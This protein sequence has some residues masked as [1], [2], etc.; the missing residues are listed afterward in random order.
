[1]ILIRTSTVWAIC[2]FLSLSLSEDSGLSDRRRK[3]MWRKVTALFLPAPKT[4]SG[5]KDLV[6]SVLAHATSVWWKAVRRRTLSLTSARHRTNPSTAGRS[7]PGRYPLTR[8]IQDQPS[9][10]LLKLQARIS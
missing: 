9:F 3:R 8:D 1:M 2:D 7:G 10:M 6:W 4:S 5:Q